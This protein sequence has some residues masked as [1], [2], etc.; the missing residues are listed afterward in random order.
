MKQFLAVFLISL[1]FQAFA[2]F[3]GNY[4]GKG[5]AIS[6]PQEKVRFC[7]QI[8]IGMKTANET[9]TV[10]QGG[11]SCGDM[12]AS[13]P[14][15]TLQIV[16][17]K[18]VSDGVVVG[19]YSDSEIDLYKQDKAEGYTFHLRLTKKAKTIVY[20]EDWTDGGKPALTVKGNLSPR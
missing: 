3:S 19:T 11:Y 10:L 14:N 8:F 5:Q 20:Q 2:S 6:H 9:L 4:S 16:G 17:A 13:Y 15:F 18:L 1:P 7:S 12:E